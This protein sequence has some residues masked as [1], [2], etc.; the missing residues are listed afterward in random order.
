MARVRPD[1]PEAQPHRLFVAVPIPP[2]VRSTMANGVEDLRR[3]CPTFRWVQPEHWHVTLRF[4][5]PTD[6]KWLP[7]IHDRITHAA[8]SFPSF[9]THLQGIGAFPSLDRARVLWIGVADPDRSWPALASVLEERLGERFAP[10]PPVSF[11]PHVTVARSRRPVALA[12]RVRTAPLDAGAF[13]VDALAL[14]RSHL[15]GAGVAYTSVG[16]YPLTGRRGAR[17]PA[18]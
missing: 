12:D 9:G 1:E 10:A 5:G 4:L 7:W 6:P 3:H 16:A 18:R 14:I 15:R 11:T 17:D 13:T 2:A 8:R